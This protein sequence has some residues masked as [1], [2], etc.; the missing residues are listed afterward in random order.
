MRL[1]KR[2]AALLAVLM[3]CTL[4]GCNEVEELKRTQAFWG[5]EK[6]GDTVE[7]GGYVYRKSEDAGVYEDIAPYSY[8]GYRQSGYVTAKD[9]PA[10]L[11]GMYGSSYSLSP[12]QYVMSVFYNTVYIREDVYDTF[13]GAKEQDMKTVWYVSVTDLGSGMFDVRTE[14]HLLSDEDGKRLEQIASDPQNAMAEDEF[15]SRYENAAGEVM[16]LNSAVIL[17]GKTHPAVKD[18]Y[19]E[20]ETI[21]TAMMYE[22]D[23]KTVILIADPEEG[24][25]HLLTEEEM[26]YFSAKLFPEQ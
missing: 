10:L 15:Y 4:T 22:R 26:D 9:V 25:Y 18:F 6:F 13:S 12:D 21:G 14:N 23:G 16:Y 3:L 8:A 11:Q 19:F 2:I 5:G 20:S 17:R 24:M 7:W 1:K